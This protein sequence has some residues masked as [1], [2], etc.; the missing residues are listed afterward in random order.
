MHFAVGDV[1]RCG[2]PT[3]GGAI[4]AVVTAA[5]PS[6]RL[7]AEHLFCDDSIWRFGSS[8]RKTGGSPLEALGLYGDGHDLSLSELFANKLSNAAEL[9]LTSSD[10]QFSQLFAVNAITTRVFDTIANT[11]DG[12]NALNAQPVDA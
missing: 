10:A 4:S 11:P 12:V 5:T 6:D 1:G 7:R 8:R 3:V 2:R 9:C